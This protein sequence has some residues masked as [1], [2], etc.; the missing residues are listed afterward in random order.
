MSLHLADRLKGEILQWIQRKHNERSP[1]TRKQ[2]LEHVEMNYGNGI[3]S[4]KHWVV[5]FLDRHSD[6][7][8][9]IPTVHRL[10][11]LEKERILAEEIQGMYAESNRI[12]PI[13]IH[14]H[15]SSGTRPSDRWIVRFRKRHLRQSNRK[16][17]DAISWTKRLITLKTTSLMPATLEVKRVMRALMT[18]NSKKDMTVV[19]LLNSI[20][21]IY[22]FIP[23]ATWWRICS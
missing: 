20:L 9:Y 23:G 13:Q 5:A 7:K 12:K 6:V 19:Q 3:E 2:I 14:T 8:Q 1:A 21:N 11:S 18:L 10:F 22:G 15:K 17:N 16:L 4:T